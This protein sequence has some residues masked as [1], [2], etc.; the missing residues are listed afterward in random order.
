MKKFRVIVTVIVITA[1]RDRNLNRDK[2]SLFFN[3]DK[4]ASL[5][6]LPPIERPG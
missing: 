5:S 2:K 3:S 4:K 1:F 6:Q